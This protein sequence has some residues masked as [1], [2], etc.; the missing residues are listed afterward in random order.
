MGTARCRDEETRARK[1]VLDE[2]EALLQLSREGDSTYIVISNEVGLG[3]VPDKTLG[4]LHRDLLGRTNQMLTSRADS[5]CWM[6][7]E[8]PIQLKTLQV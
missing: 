3:L 7:G 4:G 1:A 8:L 6:M 2:T 5:V